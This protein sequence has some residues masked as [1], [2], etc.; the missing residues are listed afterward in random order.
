MSTPRPSRRLVAVLVAGAEVARASVDPDLKYV[1]LLGTVRSAELLA[2]A[3]T[4]ARRDRQA[5]GGES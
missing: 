3:V 4:D 1:Q 2:A 5:R